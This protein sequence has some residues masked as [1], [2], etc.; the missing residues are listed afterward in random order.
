MRNARRS[1][2][3]MSFDYP[4]PGCIREGTIMARRRRLAQDLR[5]AIAYIRVS[6][7]EQAK[8]DRWSLEAQRKEIQ[9]YC[10]QRG[11]TLVAIYEDAGHSAKGGDIAK[12]PAFR[13]ML[14]DIMGIEGK[15]GNRANPCVQCDVVVTHTLDRYA[16]NLVVALTTLGELHDHGITYSSV[17]ESDF[18]YSD[19]DRRLH[20]QILAMFAEYFSEKLSVHTSK[21]KKERAGSGLYNG[22]VPY[23]YE[24]PD[25][26]T[27]KSGPGINN[28]TVPVPVLAQTE[29]V[30]RAFELY[31]TG[32]HSDLR[33]AK[34]LNAEGHRM[35]SK[36]HP[37][38]YP[39]TK[40]TLTALLQNRFY[41]GKVTY[42]GGGTRRRHGGASEVDGR[43]EPII[44][45]DLFAKAQEARA[46]K[47][48]KGHSSSA[49]RHAHPYVAAGLVHCHR[50]RQP[51]RAQGG[52]QRRPAYRDVSAERG[53][54]CM[55][56]R[57]SIGEDLVSD[58]LAT[59]IAGLTLP[60]DW[61]AI[62]LAGTTVEE[63]DAQAL[64][65]RRSELNRDL[66]RA[67]THLLRG[68]VTED[69]FT[70]RRAEIEAELASLEP[71]DV[72]DVDVDRAAALLRDL[73]AM[74]ADA[75]AE[76]RRQIA[77]DL[78]EAVYCDLDGQ[79]DY[80]VQLK[81][82]LHI[83]QSVLP[84]Q[85]VTYKSAE[86]PPKS[87]TDSDAICTS[88][89]TDGIRTRDLLRDRQAC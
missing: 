31:A 4:P 80:T 19:P 11:W 23:G 70:A 57:K 76:E 50:C 2:A 75:A 87:R 66:E 61:Q 69:Q 34:T 29:A 35:V 40:D 74:W 67:Q 45:P 49:T 9:R 14:D 42:C 41:I 13:R 62:A 54:P 8:G 22:D 10:A 63:V 12:R 83:L 7:D 68:Y 78:F 3:L 86:P 17:T 88:S 24:N 32:L 85:T 72:G 48:G 81:S 65:K 43:H 46:A 73:R 58:V 60:D 33:V 5:Y 39:F 25:R 56:K 37:D 55:T 77:H 64:T 6:G 20:L 44:D 53:I 21:G 26:G 89:G 79:T 59:A 84:K 36:A 52:G 51:L 71:R 15:D 30:R 18:D 27:D 47:R 82:T 1:N 28:S 38:G 16:R